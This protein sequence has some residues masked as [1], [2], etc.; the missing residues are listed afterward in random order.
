MN[1]TLA[2]RKTEW[3]SMNINETVTSGS[4]ENTDLSSN[5]ADLQKAGATVVRTIIDLGGV[6]ISAGTGGMVSM[7]IV[8][9]TDEEAA[10]SV[11]PDPDINYEPRGWL[12]RSQKSVF[13]SD[14]NDRSQMTTWQYDIRSARNRMWP[15]CKRPG[16]RW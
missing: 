7:G 2:R 13:C 8:M 14:P 15:T 12:W 10:A 4:Q 3:F 5:V 16:L 1:Q 11:F 9:V 6:L